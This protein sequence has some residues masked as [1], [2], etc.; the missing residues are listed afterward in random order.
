MRGV[1]QNSSPFSI[2]DSVVSTVFC[3]KGGLRRKLASLF[4][5]LPAV[6]T[7]SVLLRE[8]GPSPSVWQQVFPTAGRG[9]TPLP[10][11]GGRIHCRQHNWPS[12]CAPA[13]ASV[14]TP[15][16]GRESPAPVLPV[17]ARRRSG[18][19]DSSLRRA[20]LC[21]RGKQSPFERL[22]RIRCRTA[23]CPFSAVG[24]PGGLSQRRATAAV[25]SQRSRTGLRRP[26]ERDTTVFA[27]PFRSS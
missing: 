13:N 14:K 27:L 22:F 24:V 7:V 18:S 15:F 16:A 4:T 25:V 2:R 8:D 9:S 20:S 11:C 17:F 19:V 23:N 12:R 5:E 6:C 10:L 21:R 1:I 3:L 26:S